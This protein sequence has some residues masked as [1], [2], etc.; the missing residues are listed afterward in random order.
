MKIQS[1]LSL[2][3]FILLFASC[4]SDKPK[5]SVAGKKERNIEYLLPADSMYSVTAIGRAMKR[6]GVRHKNESNRY[7]MEGLD[8][9][10]NKNDPSA[11]IHCFRESIFYYP[12]ERNYQHL[13]TAYLRSG[14]G[15]MA[16]SVSGSLWGRIDHSECSFNDALVA[17]LG[18]DTANCMASLYDAV[19]Q[20]F[21]FKER[22][23]EEPLFAFLK[24]NA[25]WE[26]FLFSNFSDDEKLRK[27]MFSLFL[28]P[29][30]DLALPFEINVDSAASFNGDHYINYD[31]AAFVPGMEEG[32]FSRDVS[33]LYMYVGKFRTQDHIAVIYKTYNMISDTLNPVHTNIMLFDTAGMMVSETEL[34]CFCSPLESK[35]FVINKDQSIRISTYKTLWEADPL[36]KGYAGNKVVSRDEIGRTTV[37]LENGQ[38]VLKPDD[39]VAASGH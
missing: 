35:A 19:M 5:K 3:S 26:A 6:A 23:T 16:D 37:V 4:S 21:M 20:G 36:E 9:L 33:N 13:F 31:F 2:A 28:K 1:F 38:L 27:K 15:A 25:S 7:F 24:D 39:R 29:F 11:S 30:P 10:V 18:K 12:D 8:L 34:G 14:N 32:S 22:I 17:A